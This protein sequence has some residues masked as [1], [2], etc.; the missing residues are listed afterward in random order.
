[1][2][3]QDRVQV[4]KQ[5]DNSRGGNT[6]DDDMFGGPVP[7]NAQEDAVESAGVILQD[8]SNRDETTVID[9]DNADMRFRDGNN[10]T[11]V[12]LSE[13]LQVGLQNV[14]EDLT[15]ELGGNLDALV[16][17][18]LNVKVMTN[19][20]YVQITNP[21][22]AETVNWTLGQRQIITLNASVLALSFTPPPGPATLTLL[23]RQDSSG[24]R[25]VNWP[26]NVIAPDGTLK[27]DSAPNA[28][29]LVA[30]TYIPFLGQY[31][32]MSTY[33]LQPASS[34]LV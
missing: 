21:G 5:E 18:I 1:M 30:L 32:A 28:L 7:I 26:T 31:I 24:N 33:K 9:R 8:T 14:V 25:N 10:P 13:L 4:Y 34:E 15:P 2:P 11:P 12:T 6:A 27:I 19:G 23:L 3:F 20:P 29:T 22:T 16:K 17:N